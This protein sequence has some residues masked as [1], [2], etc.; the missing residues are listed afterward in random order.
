MVSDGISY[1]L[2]TTYR[3]RSCEP[4]SAKVFYSDYLDTDITVMI[5]MQHANSGMS[6]LG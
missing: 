2:Y 3:Y 4:N 5:A 6:P 1:Y